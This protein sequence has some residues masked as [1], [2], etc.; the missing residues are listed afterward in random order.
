MKNTLVFFS[1]ISSFLLLVGCQLSQDSSQEASTPKATSIKLLAQARP[2]GEA[3]DFDM[4]IDKG[5]DKLHIAHPDTL[6]MEKNEIVLGIEIEGQALAIPLYYLSGF[7]VA[8]LFM[9]SQ[10]YLLTWCPLVG[11]ARIFEGE[12]QGD[13]SGFDFG[14]G[15]VENNLLIVDRKTQTVW[16]QL[17]CKAIKGE[18][19]GEHLAPLA[20][21][22]STWEFWQRLHPD[23]KVLINTDTTEAVFP[24][25]VYKKQFY[26]LWEP[27][28]RRGFSD[29]SHKT[30]NLGLG[31]EL[32]TASVF[33]PFEKLFQETSPLAYTL[34]GQELQIH[35]DA[36][37]LTAWAENSD[38]E[39]IPNAIVYNWAWKNF[40]P[41]SEG[42]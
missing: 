16:N 4:P 34:D 38:Q 11:T 8:N 29:G 6:T 1:I 41:E 25:E 7:E 3:F 39:I 23:T 19:E 21:I 30:R 28:K 10:N 22:Q 13:R 32:G 20:S 5:L 36:E 12:I 14:R 33:F 31:I 24:T 42:Y 27:G 17:S 40:F 9:D 18:Q 15:L 2:G 26:H 37:G 35:F